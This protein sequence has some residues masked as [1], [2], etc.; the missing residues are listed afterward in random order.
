MHKK[1]IK[2]FIMFCLSI[3]IL[4]ADNSKYNLLKNSG[5]ESGT[6]G[7]DSLGATASISNTSYKGSKALKFTTGGTAQDTALLPNIEAIDG[8]SK[9]IFNGYVKHDT[10]VKGMWIG[11]VY[12]DSKW[13]TIGE[14]DKEVSITNTYKKFELIAAPPK[15]TNYITIWIWSDGGKT[16]LDEVK[17]YPKTYA[18]PSNCKLLYNGDF[19]KNLDGWSTYSKQTLIVNEAHTGAKAIQLYHGGMDQIIP[20]FGNKVDTY[21]FSGYYKTKGTPYGNWIGLDFY[22]KNDNLILTREIAVEKSKDYKKFVVNATTQKAAAYIQAWIWTEAGSKKGKLILDDLKVFTSGCN[23]DYVIP[24]ALPPHGM[25]VENS[26]VFV[27]LGFDDNTK[28]EGIDWAINILNSRKNYDQS[29]VTAS[30]YMNTIGLDEQIEDTPANLLL[31]MEKLKNSTYEMGNHTHKHQQGLN[32]TQIRNMSYTAWNNA[33]STC[34]TKLINKVGISQNKLKGFRAP[35][36]LYNNNSFRVIKDRNYLY[37]CS[38]EEG[39]AEQ[40]NGKNFR[41]PYQLN[42]GSPGHNESWIGNPENPNYLSL[43]PINDLWELPVYALIVP[44]D[45]ECE[46]YGITR[47]LWNRMKEKISYLSDHKITGFD[48]NLWSSAELN[49]AEVLGLLKYNL[50]LRLK[51]NR[52]PLTFGTHTQYYTEEWAVHAPNA[53]AQEMRQAITEFLDYARSKKE[54]RI[55][56]ASEVIKWCKNPVALP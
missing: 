4:N 42:G 13:N 32:E 51:G 21:Q 2:F 15:G 17:L 28:S 33:I 10:N 37:D 45:S 50:D 9:Y 46:K 7:W 26:P 18:P 36:L 25:S 55:N 27:V 30:F 3:N 19:E 41:W 34:D 29:N 38:I 43:D 47:G 48:Y 52:A 11:M 1:F 31:A 20:L 24:S 56:S 40:F 16:L 8:N 35:Y 54:V 23:N 53:T 39:F 12:Y 5:F 6:N 44:K 22:D 14:V 49:K